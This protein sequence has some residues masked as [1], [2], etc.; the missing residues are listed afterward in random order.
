MKK[1]L[2]FLSILA[3]LVITSCGGN[4]TTPETTGTDS[5][6]VADS[7]VKVDTTKCCI[8]TTKEVKDSTK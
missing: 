3:I 7:T 1:V 8:D 6:V 2:G 4:A 5:T